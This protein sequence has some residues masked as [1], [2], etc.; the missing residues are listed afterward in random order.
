MIN[1]ELTVQEIADDIA[2]QIPM[3]TS[4]YENTPS[5]LEKYRLRGRVGVLLEMML[6]IDP[7]LGEMLKAEWDTR[8]TSASWT[9]ELNP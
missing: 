5:E 4:A 8:T 9:D 7:E 6:A 3:I 1:P 2:R